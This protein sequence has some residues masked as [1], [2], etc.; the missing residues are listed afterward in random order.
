[1]IDPIDGTNNFIAGIQIFGTLVALRHGDESVAGCVYAPALDEVYD[2]ATGLGAR[3]NTGSIS[4]SDVTSLD[5]ATVLTGGAKHLLELGLGGLSEVLAARSKRQRGFGDF[6]MHM[7]VARG[8]AEV[9][10]E[11]DLNVWDVAALQP[12]VTEAGGTLTTLAGEPWVDG[13]PVL[14]TNGALLDTVVALA[15]EHRAFRD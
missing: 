7:L 13:G 10:I 9:V 4:V 1:M 5:A 12:I 3:L 2:A 8:A 15:A 14:T 6:W 11:G